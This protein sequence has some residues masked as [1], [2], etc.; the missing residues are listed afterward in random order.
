[1]CRVLAV[2]A[3]PNGAPPLGRF[4]LPQMLCRPCKFRSEHAGAGPTR[5][6]T[7]PRSIDRHANLF[8]GFP[9]GAH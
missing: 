8:C 6:R 7:S 1:M 5:P 4:M 2:A 3:L 9:S